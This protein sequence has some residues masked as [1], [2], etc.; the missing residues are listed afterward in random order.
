MYILDTK[1][2]EE[3][4]QRGGHR[5]MRL[6]AESHGTHSQHQH[7]KKACFNLFHFQNLVAI[8]AIKSLLK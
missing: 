6:S 8:V 5:I 3:Y 2:R 4:I 1:S 7:N